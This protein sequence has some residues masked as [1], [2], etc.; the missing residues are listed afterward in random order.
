MRGFADGW[1]EA[2]ELDEDEGEDVF[3]GLLKLGEGGAD[4]QL[5]I[6][7]GGGLLGF[8]AADEGLVE[9]PLDAGVEQ[10]GVLEVGDGAVK[11]EVDGGDG[12]VGEVREQGLDALARG[13]GFGERGEESGGLLE[14]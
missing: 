11:P 6:L 7:A 13:G 10:G 12:G 14:G 9:H 1:E 2:G 3:A 5:E 4:D 8:E